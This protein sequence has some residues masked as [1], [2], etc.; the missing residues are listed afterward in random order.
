MKGDY[1]CMELMHIAVIQTPPLMINSLRILILPQREEKEVLAGNTKQMEMLSAQT[2]AACMARR[3]LGKRRRRRNDG[4]MHGAK[5][6]WTYNNR[7]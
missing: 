7:I 1:R 2:A 4:T 3:R 5:S 6:T